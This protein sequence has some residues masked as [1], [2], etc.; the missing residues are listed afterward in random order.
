MPISTLRA[1]A[2][3]LCLERRSTA[4][5]CTT[6]I[7][8]SWQPLEKANQACAD[9]ASTG[10]TPPP[11]RN[12]TWHID[13]TQA[14]VY[15]W[16]SHKETLPIRPWVYVVVDGATSLTGLFPFKARPNADAVAA[17]LTEMSVERS[18]HGVTVGGIPEQ[19]VCDNAA[20]H[21]AR[22]MQQ[23]ALHLGWVLGPTTPYSPWQNGKAE[24]ALGLMNQ[25][26]AAKLPGALYNGTRRDGSPRQVAG[27]PA[28]IKPGDVLAWHSFTTLLTMFTDQLNTSYP[29]RRLGGRTRLQ[30]FAEDATELRHVS[31]E[32][33][34]S[35]MMLAAK[36]HACNKDGFSFRSQV[37]T[38]VP[39]HGSDSGEKSARPFKVGTYYQLRYLPTNESFIELYELGG[40]YVGQAVQAHAVT[41][42]QKDLLMLDRARQERV[43][44]AIEA[45]AI[46]HGRHLAATINQQY[47][48]ETDHSD[49]L[50]YTLAALAR[51]DSTTHDGIGSPAADVDAASST[52]PNEPRSR[53]HASE[54]QADVS[55]GR[56]TGPTSSARLGRP[57]DATS[58]RPRGK[59]S[60]PS[61][62]H[63]SGLAGPAR[64]PLPR[65][66]TGTNA[67]NDEV[68]TRRTTDRL[69]ATMSDLFDDD[70]GRA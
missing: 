38:P 9:T 62:L 58:A 8:R 69:A 10:D 30:A 5:C 4:P 70:P 37:Y 54:G 56:V 2:R 21:F 51:P 26:L 3:S 67:S 35:A 19:I 39:V 33:I 18:M 22:T 24:R 34:R 20:E 43:T 63:N 40:T 64:S 32:Q 65:I 36:P 68:V 45:G 46:E 15:V 42:E 13:A 57:A 1:R 50:D 66:R 31:P 59:R 7:R 25:K 17:V 61:R 28:D 16:P 11:H 53:D 55:A 48:H 14:D 47:G 23:A 44:R 52:G 29:L 41:K 6:P 49:M 27:L 60:E 12:H